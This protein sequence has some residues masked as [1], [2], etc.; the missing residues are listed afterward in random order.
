MA[1]QKITQ[2]NANAA[3][4][5]ADLLVVVDDPGGVP[6]TQKQT[7]AVHHTFIDYKYFPISESNPG[8]S[9]PAPVSDLDAGSVVV[10]VSNFDPAADEEVY[11]IWQPPSDIVV[12]SGIYFRVV[13]FVSNVVGPV[14]E[15]VTFML[16][17]VSLGDTDGLDDVPGVDVASEI[18]DVTAAQYD[19]LVSAWSAVVTVTDLAAGETVVLHLYR[20]PDAA[21]DDYVQDIA[22]AGLEIKYYRTLAN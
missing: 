6:E 1:D 17:G 7:V 8:P 19:R 11:F 9:P 3:P 16:E 2:L 22:V 10:K 21:N 13:C 14:V 4:N 5:A 15:G 18:V 12:A 20:D